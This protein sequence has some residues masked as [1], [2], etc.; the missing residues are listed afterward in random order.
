MWYLILLFV[1][2]A[3][4]DF[5]IWHSYVKGKK[6][7]YS[8]LYWLPLIITVASFALGLS[9]VLTRIFLRV[10][11]VLF[12]GVSI[13]KLVF[14]I[15]SAIGRLLGRVM[16]KALL[17]RNTLAFGVAILVLCC[18]LYGFT[19]GWKRLTLDEF[20]VTAGVPQAFD[21][22]RIVQLSDLHVGTFDYDPAVLDSI[23]EEVNA[24]HPDV[25][26]FTGDLIN[27]TPDE[28]NPYMSTLAKLKAKDGVYSIM[29]NH[30]YCYYDKQATP[31]EIEIRI[32]DL[33]QR[34][35]EMG[36]DLLLNEHRIIERDG[37]KLAIIGVENDSK[38]PHPQLGDLPKAMAGVPDDA[39]KILLTHDPSHW[40]R[41]VLP[42]TDIPLTLS[43]HTHAMQVKVGKYS[44]SQLIYD[45][46]G[47]KFKE[48]D[49]LLNVNTGTGQNVP[50][51]FGAWP[52]ISVITLKAKKE[53]A[54]IPSL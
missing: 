6:K 54:V 35:R 31:Q 4:P 32:E 43:G 42:T 18:A 7:I 10:F 15:I 44:P 13:P 3:L 30:D 9:G 52:E 34:Q 11:F 37:Q 40:K 17:V 8:L 48:G 1:V 26:F 38:P 49:Q 51:R 29:G 28:L 50:F 25:I 24:L 16:P 46:W 21:D 2:I 19:Y 33:K 14:V 45:E 47:G 5:Y 22:Y 20:E 12:F 53:K 41:E 23:V 27:I 39:Y 36:W